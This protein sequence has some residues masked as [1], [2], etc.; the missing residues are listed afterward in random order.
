[1]E[2]YR[3]VPFAVATAVA[4]IATLF[5][6]GNRLLQLPEQ[7]QAFTMVVQL[8]GAFSFALLVVCAWFTWGDSRK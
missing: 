1:H 5:T 3:V 4:Y 2:R 8:L 6:L 7:M